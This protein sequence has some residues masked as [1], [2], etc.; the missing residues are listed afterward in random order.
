MNTDKPTPP[1]GYEVTRW[2]NLP[3][4]I[5]ESC[6][7]WFEEG[8]QW[9]ESGNSGF[10]KETVISDVWYAVPVQKPHQDF[11]I[12]D[13]PIPDSRGYSPVQKLA[14]EQPT[15]PKGY[16]V[17]R[18]WDIP[19]DTPEGS[20]VW[21]PVFSRWIASG[22]IENAAT[23]DL[24]YAVP[25]TSTDP[26]KAMGDQKPQLQLVPPALNVSVAAALKNGIDKG[27][28]PFN[29]RETPVEVMTY[30]GAIRRHLDDF[31]DGEDIATDSKVHHM[32]HIAANCAIILD[33]AKHGTLVDNRPPK[34]QTV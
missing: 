28:G 2:V 17:L 30:L 18:G 16:T 13:K 27:Y 22:N 11:D 34:A 8:H 14:D 19:G 3:D 5:P 12:Y 26:K 15:P 23:R 10:P 20:M 4:L 31:L 1:E 33:A 7:Y 29:W 21:R 32:G 25:I 24:W 9:R 6:K